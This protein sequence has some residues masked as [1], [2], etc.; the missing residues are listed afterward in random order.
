MGNSI[1]LGKCPK[2]SIKLQDKEL[3]NLKQ[4]ESARCFKCGKLYTNKPFWI[5]LKLILMVSL[6]FVAPLLKIK[7]VTLIACMI[8]FILVALYHQIQAYLPLIEEQNVAT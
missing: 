8:S 6:P 4:G 2:C 5:F 3:E 1:M 7:A